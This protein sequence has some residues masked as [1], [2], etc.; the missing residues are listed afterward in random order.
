M[1]LEGIS[2][3]PFL[4]SVLN[5]VLYPLTRARKEIFVLA[6]SALND[7]ADGKFASINA[8]GGPV[9]CQVHVYGPNLAYFRKNLNLP[10]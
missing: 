2:I 8:G 3:D 6:F 5:T 9:R 7:F 4:L 1:S 10:T